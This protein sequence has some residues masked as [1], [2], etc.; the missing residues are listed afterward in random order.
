[1]NN[2][3]KKQ[4]RLEKLS[5]QYEKHKGKVDQ[6]GREIKELTKEIEMDSMAD[7]FQEGKVNKMTVNDWK[8]VRDS[9]STGALQKFLKQNFGEETDHEKKEPEESLDNEDK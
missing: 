4:A 9:I 6:L 3:E 8:L 5:E 7:V 2:L 1:M